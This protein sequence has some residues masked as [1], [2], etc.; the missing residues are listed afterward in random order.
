MVRD[1]LRGGGG[2]FGSMCG[3]LF[4]WESL[5]SFAVKTFGSGADLFIPILRDRFLMKLKSNIS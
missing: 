4:L 1:W 3:G 2:P 5:S